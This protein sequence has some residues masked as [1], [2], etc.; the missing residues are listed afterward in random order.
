MLHPCIELIG[1]D[2]SAVDEQIGITPDGRREMRIGAE[3]EAKVPSV[4]RP[5]IGLRL[6]A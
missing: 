6:A 5:I 1:I 2:Q 4:R 3:R